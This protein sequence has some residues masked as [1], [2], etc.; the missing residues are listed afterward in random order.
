MKIIDVQRV[1]LDIIVKSL[2]SSFSSE[3]EHAVCHHCHHHHHQYHH[4]QNSNMLSAILCLIK[5]IDAPSLEVVEL[6]ARLSFSREM[7]IFKSFKCTSKKTG[8][9]MKKRSC[10]SD[11]LSCRCRMEELDD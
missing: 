1:T 5:E 7:N 2:I 8:H 4:L 9:T 10:T 6:A 11:E 3:L